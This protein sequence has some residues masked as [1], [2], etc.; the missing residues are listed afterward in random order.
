MLRFNAITNDVTRCS[1][2]HNYLFVLPYVFAEGKMLRFNAITNDV[3]RCSYPHNY[4][5]VLP[6]VPTFNETIEGDLITIG[7]YNYNKCISC[8]VKIYNINT[9]SWSEG[10]YLPYGVDYHTTVVVDE[11][12]Y[13]IGGTTTK[14]RVSKSVI[15]YRGGEWNTLA[16]LLFEGQD[17]LA[18]LRDNCIY[19]YG[20][21]G[22]LSMVR[23]PQC[24]N[25]TTNV[26]TIL[27]TDVLVWL[28]FIDVRLSNSVYNESEIY[29]C[30]D[31]D[32][33]S[34]CLKNKYR[35]LLYSDIT[36]IYNCLILM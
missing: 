23:K 3:T 11:D 14:D 24:Y 1:Y 32:I 4:L 35:T 21:F 15:R 16:P 12:I 18:L 19:V 13:V 33:Y 2:P 34:I 31:R 6:Y 25:I 26:W 10:K 28:T 8:E 17:Y 5:F 30:S 7:G 9:D 29:V 36:D 22:I 20:G 27:H